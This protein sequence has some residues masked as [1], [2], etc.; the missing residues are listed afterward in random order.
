MTEPGD[1]MLLVIVG[2]Q[3]MILRTDECLEVP[4][5]LPGKLP[6]KDGLAG[7]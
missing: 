2:R 3:P 6:E 7:R 5:S 1:G 4:P